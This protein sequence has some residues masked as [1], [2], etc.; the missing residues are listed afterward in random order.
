MV[1]VVMMAAAAV[2]AAVVVL[3]IGLAAAVVVLLIG[4]AAAVSVVPEVLAVVAAEMNVLPFSFDMVSAPNAAAARL[5]RPASSSS[6]PRRPV[7]GE[8]D[9]EGED[10][11]DEGEEETGDEG[12]EGEEEEEKMEDVNMAVEAE[13]W[14]SD[15]LRALR[16]SRS[17]YT[18]HQRLKVLPER[19]VSNYQYSIQSLG[20]WRDKG[21]RDHAV[22]VLTFQPP[23]HS[24]H[25]SC[26]SSASAAAIVS[27]R[28]SASCDGERA[29]G[30]LDPLG[31]LQK[32]L[33]T[34]DT[35]YPRHATSADGRILRTA[36]LCS[37]TASAGCTVAV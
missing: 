9:G 18:L 19:C 27:N 3:L 36:L 35:P 32:S 16:R 8:Q 1:V 11:E 14:R 7:Y 12:E 24:P 37:V 22:R 4:L 33:R 13:V 28:C 15:M 26:F 5:K 21:A 6:L 2:A 10:G 20:K 30:A 23:I 25:G 17:A 34:S 31:R 29:A